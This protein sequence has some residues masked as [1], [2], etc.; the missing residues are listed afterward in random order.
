MKKLFIIR[1]AKSDWSDF[2]LDD[3]DRPLKKRGLRNAPFMGSLLKQKDIYPDI[4][5]SSPANRAITTAK[6][7]AQNIEYKD[8][9]VQIDSIYESSLSNL[10]KIIRSI[11]DKN[12]IAFIV[13]HNPSLNSLGFN[14]CDFDENIVTCGIVEIEFEVNNW[15]DISNKNSK[16]I[17][18]E[19]PKKYS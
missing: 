19:Y 6:L 13:G 7:I 2:S 9:I 15:K 14:L 18:F 4:F 11:E 12:E 17:S 16:F 10:L 1:H 3:F 8:E 5:L